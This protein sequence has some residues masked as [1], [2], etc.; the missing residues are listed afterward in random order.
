MLDQLLRRTRSGRITI[1]YWDGTR[2]TYGTDGERLGLTIKKPGVVRKLLRS[3]SMAFGEA[4]MQK[5]IE[6]TEGD[7]GVFFRLQTANRSMGL[8]RLSSLRLYRNQR[9]HHRRQQS[10]ISHHYDVGNDYYKLFLD[11]TLTYSCAYFQKAGD[12][13]EQAQRQKIDLVL[14]KL[15]LQKG[16]RLLDIGSGWGHL[17]VTAA[18]Q[19]GAT[20]LGVTLS[21][22]QLTGARELA[23]RE[24]VADK[25]RFELANYQDL[26]AGEP[27]DRIV[28]VGMFEHVGRDNHAS[29]FA[30][31]GELL[32]EDGL[33]LLHTITS[34]Y[35]NP[36][37]AWID[38]YIFPGG[39]LPT[40]SRIERHLEAA[41][42]WS[43][44]RENLW[45]H[46]AMTLHEW[47]QRHARNRAKIIVMYDEVFYRMR[48]LW[49]AGSEAAFA[50]GDL[51]LAQI[52]FTKRKPVMGEWPL[53]RDYLY[54]S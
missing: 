49:L 11:Q 22:E 39:Y 45:Q 15:R 16:Q 21:R 26:P 28:S 46:Y 6:I 10:Q 13:L 34:Q 17:A 19:Y 42:M 12:S 20:V 38:R 35:G 33:S 24:G 5:D 54:K 43:I 18:K 51:G 37:D 52:I 27:F 8:T 29:Y 36:N 9:N 47:A 41:D 4:Y 3:P 30:K 25:V 7:L 53:T 44:D 32:T 40:V 2:T 31:V 1:K 23:E 48:E 50:H 14:R